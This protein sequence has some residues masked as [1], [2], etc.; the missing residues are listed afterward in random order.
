MY[1]CVCMYVFVC[2]YMGMCMLLYVC[3]LYVIVYV[4]MCVCVYVCLCVCVYVCMCVCVRVLGEEYTLEVTNLSHKTV[5]AHQT[6]EE[7]AKAA[8]MAQDAWKKL[9]PKANTLRQVT[10]KEPPRNHQGQQAGEKVFKAKHSSEGEYKD[11]RPDTQQQHPD[12]HH[13]LE[14]SVHDKIPHDKTESR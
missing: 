4:C 10:D 1:V 14:Q 8:E 9:R 11:T 13:H 6:E 3:F 2:V 12:D 7:R 5:V